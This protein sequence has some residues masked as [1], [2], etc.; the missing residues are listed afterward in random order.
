MQT[1]KDWYLARLR[2]I[3]ARQSARTPMGLVADDKLLIQQH[4]LESTNS[5]TKQKEHIEGLL[6]AKDNARA[7]KVILCLLTFGGAA[8]LALLTFLAQQ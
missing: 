7:H 4:V 6:V 2:A 1:L 8:L 3:A 5:S